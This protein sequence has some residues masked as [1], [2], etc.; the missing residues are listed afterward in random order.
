VQHSIFAMEVCARLDVNAGMLA[1]LRDCIVQQPV[2]ATLQQKWTM[3]RRAAE[4]VAANLQHVERGC[5]DYFDDDARALRDFDMW[6]KGMTTEEGARTAPSGVPDPYRGEPRYL[7]FTMAFLLVHGTPTD[8]AIATLCQIPE[9]DL[10]RRDVFHRILRGL[11][12]V[13]FASVKSDVM[14]LIPRDGD[15]GLTAQ[16]MAHAKFHYLRPLI[17]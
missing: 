13:N 5:W 15:W 9:A 10:W 16:D 14:Y 12:V 1:T 3:Y 7:T 11:G 4:L 8:R 17:G 2:A 6:L